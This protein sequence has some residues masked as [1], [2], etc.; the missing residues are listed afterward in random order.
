MSTIFQKL[1]SIDNK[2]K[3]SVFG[4]IRWWQTQKSLDNI[5]ALISYLVLN[6]YYHNEYFAKCGTRVKLSNNNMTVAKY[7]TVGDGYNTTYGNTW[8]DSNI[9]QIAK[10]RLKLKWTGLIFISIVSK[11]DKV[12]DGFMYDD[13]IPFYSFGIDGSRW[14]KEG[15]FDDKYLTN[16]AGNWEDIVLD[17][18]ALILDTKNNTIGVQKDESAQGCRKRMDSM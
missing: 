9:P 11:D 1:N 4:Y 18:F 2:I 8:I 17:E 13:C 12:D 5:P 6:Y 16:P 7:E 10:W 3:Y 15:D 14:T